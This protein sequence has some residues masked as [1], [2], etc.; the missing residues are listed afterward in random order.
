MA[1]VIA[2]TV[3]KTK[4]DGLNYFKKSLCLRQ[5]NSAWRL[6]K[7]LLPKTKNTD[8]EKS[9]F[10]FPKKSGLCELY[11]IVKIFIARCVM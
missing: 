9:P 7:S 10:F 4:H 3:V 6:K 11:I 8:D 2:K 1:S 5:R